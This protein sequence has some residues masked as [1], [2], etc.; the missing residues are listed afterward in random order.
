MGTFARFT[1]FYVHEYEV[2]WRIHIYYS[3]HTFIHHVD[4]CVCLSHARVARPR[5]MATIVGKEAA[6]SSLIL[7]AS[8]PVLFVVQALSSIMTD[9]R[10]LMMGLV[11]VLFEGSMLAWIIIWVPA[12]K[13]AMPVCA[14]IRVSLVG[15]TGHLIPSLVVSFIVCRAVGLSL[16]VVSRSTYS[17]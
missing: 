16:C 13:G 12:L 5:P 2:S 3:V 1:S 4:G 10:L 7:T 17:R 9:G 6:L 8:F 15:S 11:Q 14:H